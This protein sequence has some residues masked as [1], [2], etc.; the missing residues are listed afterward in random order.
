MATLCV[1]PFLI[2]SMQLSMLQVNLLL[3]AETV[4][5][6][7][8]GLLIQEQGYTEL[9]GSAVKHERGRGISEWVG[10]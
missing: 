4:L 6:V 7:K 3:V 10:G 8:H 1:V 5:T 9:I 2:G